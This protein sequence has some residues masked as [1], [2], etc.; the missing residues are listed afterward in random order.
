MNVQVKHNGVDISDYVISYERTHYIC[1]SVGEMQMILSATYSPEIVPHDDIKVYENGD[2]KVTYY[3]SDVDRSVP[4]GTITLQ[5]QDRSKYIVDYFIPDSYT[6]D[7]PSYTRFWIEKF[8]DEAGVNYSFT[9]ASQGNL[10][11]NFTALGL[12]PAYDQIMMLLQLSGW[13]MYFDGD[14]TAIIGTLDTDLAETAGFVNKSDILEIKKITDD[15]ML[16]N[17]AVVWGQFDG[18]RNEYAFA[19][20][21]VDTPYNYDTRDKRA[22]VISNNNIPNKSSAYGIANILIKEFAKATIEKHMVIHGARNW[23]LGESLRVNSG[24]WRGKGLI[25]TFGVRMDRNG[26]VTTIILDER[27]P[28]LYGFFNFG[29]YVYV[30]TFGDGIW[31]KHIKFDP[32]FYNFSTGLTNLNITDL[33][34]KNGVFGSVAAS[35]EMFYANSEE[36][37]WYPIQQESLPSP[38]DAVPSGNLDYIEFSGIMARAIIIDKETNNVKFGVDTFSGLNLGDYFMIYSSFVTA[39][40]I[41][42][43]GS[44]GWIVDYDPFTG[45]LTGGLGSGI[46][47][48]HYS[49]DYN[50][51][52]LDLENDGV[53]DYVSVKWGSGGAN[54]EVADFGRHTSTMTTGANSAYLDPF[55]KVNIATIDYDRDQT[56]LGTISNETAYFSIFN[57]ET[58]DERDVVTAIFTSGSWKLR[59]LSFHITEVDDEE[60]IYTSETTSGTFSATGISFIGVYRLAKGLYNIFYGPVANSGN[61]ITVDIKYRT[62]DSNANSLTS[63]VV[64]NTFSISKDVAGNTNENISAASQIVGNNMFLYLLHARRANLGTAYPTPNY[65]E[66]Q[67]MAVDMEA[68]TTS[69]SAGSINFGDGG[70]PPPGGVDNFFSEPLTPTITNGFTFQ[71]G[72]SGLLVHAVQTYNTFDDT[73]HN[74]L[75][76]V[77]NGIFSAVE[78]QTA[79][80]ASDSSFVY[81]G[82]STGFLRGQ[83]T[84]NYCIYS[85]FTNPGAYFI[86]NGNTINIGTGTFPPHGGARTV[87]PPTGDRYLVNLA[88]TW[89]WE[90]AVDYSLDGPLVFPTGYTIINPFQT[91]NN[92]LDEYFWFA[93][94]DSDSEK[95]ILKLSKYGNLMSVILPANTFGALWPTF[96]YGFVI[97]NF[98]INPQNSTVLYI[99]NKVFSDSGYLVLQRD[100][101]DYNLIREAG[102][103][104]RIDISNNSPVLSVL[105][106]QSTFRSD[107]IFNGEGRIVAPLN[108]GILTFKNVY[109]YRY[110]MLETSDGVIVASGEGATNQV[111]YASES[112]I[113]TSDAQS[114]SGGFVL[115]DTSPSGISRIETSNFT[116]PGQFIFVTAS[117]T[118]E[119]EP[120][121]FYQKNNDDLTF[122]YYSGLPA[123]RATIIRVD[124]RF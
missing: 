71:N 23:N 64:L 42:A 45:E 104:I 102:A 7:Y 111:L 43:S 62:W 110:A 9:T 112:G 67:T 61:T 79:T 5:C 21:S 15:K 115:M 16:R 123:S 54:Y 49:G 73:Y 69:L 51:I 88:G 57:N 82:G 46:Y 12:Q 96:N 84:Q 24:V 77:E 17:R 101:M 85:V 97:G 3:V 44:R 116:Y 98:F 72:M 113:W 117:A 53:N 70:F 109:D 83:R 68:I 18:F 37:P 89:Y 14:G 26:L 31:R 119:E 25:T 118:M 91:A 56:E 22:M 33:H 50:I 122:T 103:P 6:I 87:N 60:V 92:N 114:Y 48:I 2:F 11:S 63:E 80:G 106:D 75:I 13:F 100:G 95:V 93:I 121:M 78:F 40:G 55:A 1:S 105:G 58:V 66:V 59:K 65:Y 35:G 41:T 38:R 20:I 81:Q 39:S 86:Y 32:A 30:G 47:P 94:R 29:D 52:V 74:W 108:S 36:G 34:I 27:C 19:D 124:D 4:D 120:P 90:S 99:N 28:R 10:L 76:T 8:L 107:F